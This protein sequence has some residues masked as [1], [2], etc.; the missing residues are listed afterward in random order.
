MLVIVLAGFAPTLTLR[1]LFDVAAI[2]AYLYVHGFTLTGFVRSAFCA[3]GSHCIRA[4]FRAPSAGYRGYHS[5]RVYSRNWA[6]GYFGWAI[7][8]S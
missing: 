8:T 3:S 5:R 7:E 6:H 1:P 4:G 2:P